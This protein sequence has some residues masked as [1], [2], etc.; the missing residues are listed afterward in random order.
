MAYRTT[1][2]RHTWSIFTDGFAGSVHLGYRDRRSC[3]R[4]AKS[5]LT[6]SWYLNGG[7]HPLGIVS[8]DGQMNG[9]LPTDFEFDDPYLDESIRYDLNN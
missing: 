8:T 6:N 4:K 5:A 9:G 3:E 7:W 1:C 2:P